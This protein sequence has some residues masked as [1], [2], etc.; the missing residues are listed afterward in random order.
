MNTG[1]IGIVI[2]LLF[3][4]CGGGDLYAQSVNYDHWVGEHYGT[5]EGLPN[6]TVHGATRD[7]NQLL[8]VG[9]ESGL[10]LLDGYRV[11]V[12]KDFPQRFNG[13]LKRD[14]EGLIIASLSGHPDS[15]EFFDPTTFRAAGKRGE[16]AFLLLRRAAKIGWFMLWQ[17]NSCL[18]ITL[19]MPIVQAS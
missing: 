1:R 6:R 8:W 5:D 15:V 10:S 14:N 19:S 7:N 3:L 18:A 2:I 11:K 17:M 13:D 9:T 12:F 16:M 4:L